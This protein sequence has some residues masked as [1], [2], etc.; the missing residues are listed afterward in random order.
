MDL[1]IAA[2][3]ITEIVGVAVAQGTVTGALKS[4]LTNEWT[5]YVATQTIKCTENVG[6]TV[7]KEQL[8]EH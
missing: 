6:V 5:L 7:T 4:A 1:G 2:Q 8:L 3:A